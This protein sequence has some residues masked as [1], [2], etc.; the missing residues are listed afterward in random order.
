MSL[1]AWLEP[2]FDAARMRAIDA[3]AIE[4]RGVPSLELMERAG[5]ALAAVAA[6]MAPAGRI[7]VVAGK[8]NNAGDGFVAA[9]VLREGG[10]DVD[11]LLTGAASE[12]SG[13]AA[14]NLERLAG[15]APVTL[16]HGIAA[17][18]ALVIDCLLGTGA[19]GEPRGGIAE[20]ITAIRSCDA[21]V[22]AADV[23]SG[24]N[25]SD[26]ETAGLAVL[27]DATATFHA[28]K[29]GL[30]INPGRGCAG[31]VRV[32]DIGIPQGAPVEADAGLIHDEVL[33]SV[34]RRGVG[35]TKFSSGRVLVAGGSAGLT[36][37]PCLAALAAARAGAGYVTVCVPASLSVVFESRLLETMTIAL[38][39]DGGAHTA[40]GVDGL[41]EAASARGGALVLGPGLGRSAGA[42]AFARGVLGAVAL[43]VVLD[44]DGLNAYAGD[45]E[46]LRGS[47]AAVLTPHE[48]ELARLLGAEEGGAAIAAARL[49]CAREA[50][51]RAGAVIVLKGDDTIVA[52]P[53]GLVAVSPGATPAL[54]TAGTGDVLSGVI[55]AMLAKG[56]EPFEA[57]SA[58]VR[59]H[60]LAGIRAAAERG[61]REGVIASD[62]IDALAAVR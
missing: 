48:G 35:S 38:P 47:A 16:E 9:R 12:L 5:T 54:A 40:A 23:P 17:D 52:A 36:G 25:A 34:P 28:A 7:V 14:A 37:A 57:A 24:V 46:G 21:P 62:V 53:G 27:A 20:A 61:S 10:R 6:S 31:S 51:K 45:L 19:S 43:P 13:D 41:L 32:I 50:S 60:A 3:W 22:L 42:A 59:L 30:W 4:Q 15:A 56:L 55:A 33:A 29:P 18:A 2:L 11:V 1:P 58:G 49:S 44:A 26:G 39:D 8:G